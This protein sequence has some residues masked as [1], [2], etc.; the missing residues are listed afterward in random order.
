MK[1]TDLPQFASLARRKDVKVIRHKDTKID[2]LQLYHQGKFD[3]YQNG[4]SRD[5]FAKASYLISFLAERDK[6]AKFIGVYKVK[7][8]RPKHNGFRY[9]TKK[10]DGFSDLEDRLVVYWG[11]GTRSWYQ[12]LHSKGDK[13]INEI[14][15]PGYVKDFPGF[16]DF[17]LTYAELR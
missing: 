7:G 2:L 8:V 1:I 16:Y 14:L 11:E 9:Y 6:Y 17:T 13:A 12:W 15:P 4:Q 5:V 10:L 3:D